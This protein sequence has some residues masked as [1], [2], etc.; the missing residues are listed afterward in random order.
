MVAESLL[1][2]Q[3]GDT[4]E[5]RE[6]FLP[7][8]MPSQCIGDG[9]YGQVW[10]ARCNGKLYAVKKYTKSTVHHVPQGLVD[11]INLN[12]KHENVVTYC[13]IGFGLFEGTRHFAVAMEKEEQDLPTFISENKTLWPIKKLSILTGV[14]NGLAY[15]HSKGIVHC[16]LRPSNVLVTPKSTVK[17]SDYGNTCVVPISTACIEC[18]LEDAICRDYFPPE[19]EEREKHNISFDSFSFGHLSL[20]VVLQKHPHPL[21]RH[22][23]VENGETIT[24]TEVGRREE[25]IREMGEVVSGNVLEPLLPWTEQCLSDEEYE[26]PQLANF[27]ALCLLRDT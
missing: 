20:Y 22:N 21:K 13:G 14:A 17:I 23:S 1:C 10:E 6:P 9:L 12:L 26:R 2:G 16:D 7:R 25:F 8:L 5:V 11:L 4:S 3:K 27:E 15:L 24:R 18:R 19:A